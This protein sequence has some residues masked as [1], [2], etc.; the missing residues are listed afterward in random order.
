MLAVHCNHCCRDFDR[1]STLLPKGNVGKRRL[2]E[3]LAIREPL[4]RGEDSAKG[5]VE[6]HGLATQ[7]RD[8]RVTGPLQLLQL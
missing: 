8:V 2:S 1:G 4:L 5:D 6:G 3:A 7:E